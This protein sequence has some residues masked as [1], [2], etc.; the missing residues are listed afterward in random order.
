M[1]PSVKNRQTMDILKKLR[2][3][4]A[5]RRDDE[6][7]TVSLDMTLPRPKKLEAELEG[8]SEAE[9]DEA[10]GGEEGNEEDLEEVPPVMPVPAGPNLRPKKKRQ[11]LP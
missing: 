8:E 10:E 1:I 3:Q 7:G 6:I 4:G 2:Q 5:P 9:M 11:N